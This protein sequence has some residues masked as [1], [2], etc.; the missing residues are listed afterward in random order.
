MGKRIKRFDFVPRDPPQVGFESR[1]MGDYPARF[2]EHLYVVCAGEWK[3][4][5]KKEAALPTAPSPLTLFIIM[6]NQCIKMLI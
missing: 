6:V 5:S 3:P 4:P 1:V 2:G